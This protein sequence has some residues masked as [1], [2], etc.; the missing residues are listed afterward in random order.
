MPEDGDGEDHA[1]RNV[2][3]VSAAHH[4]SELHRDRKELLYLAVRAEQPRVQ[5]GKGTGHPAVR[6]RQPFGAASPTQAR[7]SERTP[8][9]SSR[10]TSR[11]S[12]TSP[13]T[14]T[15]FRRSYA[16]GSCWD[17]TGRSSRW[18]VGATTSCTPKWSSASASWTS[19]RCRRPSTTT[20]STSG[21][22]CSPKT[23]RAAA[24]NTAAC[25]KTNTS[26]RC[27][28]PTGLPT[29]R[30]YAWRIWAGKRCWLHA[31]TPP[32]AR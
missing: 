14:A 3:R 7:C 15:A 10:T 23:Y 26:W 18:P 8:R 5:P 19:A 4:Q 9:R 31:S 25:T 16:S 32:K 20:S 1:R 2:V 30:A 13:I 21:S 12:A 24:T 11:R 28:R 27:P 6:A 22:R 17:R 29:A